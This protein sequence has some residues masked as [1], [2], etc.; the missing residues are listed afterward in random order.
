RHIQVEHGHVGL[1]FG[2]AG[3][4]LVAVFGLGDDL[5]PKVTRNDLLQS[6]AKDRGIIGD[7]NAKGSVIHLNRHPLKRN[8]PYSPFCMFSFTTTSIVVSCPGAERIASSPLSRRAR[9]A[10]PDSPKPVWP[11]LSGERS[12]CGLKPLP[13]SLIVRRMRAAS[14][15]SVTRASVACECLT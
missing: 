7:Q 2:E 5:Q 3:D 11:L 14:R 10:I 1:K 4:G 15:L 8:F 12:V 9:S 6:F 13:L